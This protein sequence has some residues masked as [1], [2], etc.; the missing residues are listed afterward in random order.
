M[1]DFSKFKKIDFVDKKIEPIQEEKKTDAETIR[2]VEKIP[3]IKV[4]VDRKK[5]KTQLTI[6]IRKIFER[7]QQLPKHKQKIPI[8]Y[9]RTT[10]LFLR[11][12]EKRF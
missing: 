11:T 8:E 5:T 1:V 12:L 9:Y 7:D 10:E 6:N 3:K 4:K 2:K